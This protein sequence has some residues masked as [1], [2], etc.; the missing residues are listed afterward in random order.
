MEAKTGV[1]SSFRVPGYMGA[2]ARTANDLLF[3]FSK[4]TSQM[5]TLIKKEQLFF[6]QFEAHF[7]ATHKPPLSNNIQLTF[8]AHWSLYSWKEQC[9]AWALSGKILLPIKTLG[10]EVMHSYSQEGEKFI[11]S[12]LSW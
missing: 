7:E 5:H 9:L 11:V 12:V 8:D 4:N 10:T 2:A 3:T 1:G 6:I